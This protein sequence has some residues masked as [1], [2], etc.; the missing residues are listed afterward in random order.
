MQSLHEGL[1][2]G[3]HFSHPLDPLRRETRAEVGDYREGLEVIS[4]VGVERKAVHVV[5]EISGSCKVFELFGR[6]LSRA[7]GEEVPEHVGDGASV[8]LIDV[9]EH[10]KQEVA[11]LQEQEIQDCDGL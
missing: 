1:V 11:A 8:F 3:P 9:I 4:V 7:A 2:V 6:F 10:T 5:H